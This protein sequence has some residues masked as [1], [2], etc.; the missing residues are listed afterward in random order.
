MTTE[1]GEISTK[2]NQAKISVLPS[3]RCMRRGLPNTQ[4]CAGEL[5]PVAD[6]CQVEFKSLTFKF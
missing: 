3:S 2:L 1:E 4:L 5:N 6:S